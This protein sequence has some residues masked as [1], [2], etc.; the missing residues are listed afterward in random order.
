ME[1]RHHMAVKAYRHPNHIVR[2]QFETFWRRQKVCDTHSSHQVM[3]RRRVKWWSAYQ[4]QLLTVRRLEET[5]KD[6]CF[7]SLVGYV[8]LGRCCNCYPICPVPEIEIL[9]GV[10]CLPKSISAYVVWNSV[11][12]L[13]ISSV[14][15]H[16]GGVCHPSAPLQNQTMS[17]AYAMWVWG[18]TLG[19][20]P[21]FILLMLFL[22]SL[23]VCRSL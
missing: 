4:T 18:L 1:H 21:C 10:E 13:T 15:V 9:Y 16:Q 2:I 12:F 5:A 11:C 20:V 8:Q 19:F 6:I 3:A 23:R 7:W 22:P 14:Q 17:P